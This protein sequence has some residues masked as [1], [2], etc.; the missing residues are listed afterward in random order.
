MKETL[1]TAQA[2]E[3]LNVAQPTVKLWCRQGKFPHATLEQT[4]RGPVWQ[5]PVSDLKDFTPPQ[6]GRP[7]KTPPQ[8][9]TAAKKSRG[10]P[11]KDREAKP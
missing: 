7:K 8:E 5:I 1:T 3:R 11:R 4:A 10:R 6:M 2:A 9:E